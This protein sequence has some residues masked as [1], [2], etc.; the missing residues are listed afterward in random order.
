M[1]KQTALTAASLLTL[2]A[3]LAPNVLAEE[4]TLS[5]DIL[6]TNDLHATITDFGKV[7][8]FIDSVREEADHSLYLDA[9][10]IFSGSPVVDLPLGEPIITLLNEMGLEAMTI[11]NH[12]FD[13][14]QEA[15]AAR[16][17]EADFSWLSANTNVTDPTIPIEQPDPYEI[18]TFD[19]I[20]VGVLSLTQNPPATRPAGV[21][22][23]EFADYSDTIEEYDYLRDE[24]DILIALTHVGFGADQRIAEEFD[25]FDAIIGGH[26]HTTLTEPE[27]VNGTPIFQT[28]GY[29]ENVG[30]VTVEID[31]ASGDVTVDGYLQ[32][33]DEIT[34]VNASVA[35][36]VETYISDSEELLFQVVGTTETGL[37]RDP[38][39]DRDTSLG[40]FWTDAMRHA[41]DADFA[42][43]NN[44]GLRASIPAGEL[45]AN[46]I[47]TVEPFNN[48]VTEIL[49]TGEAFKEVLIYSFNR[50][51]SIDL[52]ASGF[53]YIVYVD[54][55]GK[56]VDIDL[57][58]DGEPLDLTAT[59]SVAL[60][61]FM[62]E[63]GSG[64]DFTDSTLIQEL[65]GPV[66]QAMF[67]YIE[68][69]DGEVNYDEAGENRIGIFPADERETPEVPAPVDFPFIDVPT[70]NFAYAYIQSLHA[71]GIINGMSETMFAPKGITTRGQFSAML[72]RLLDLEFDGADLP[73][74]L[75]GD[76]GAEIAALV[77]AGIVEG[78]PDGTFRQ[79]VV[80]SRQEM[81]VMAIRAL[82]YAVADELPVGSA[83]T[84]ADEDQISPYARES[85]QTAVE[86]G[87]IGGMTET[88]V[89]PLGYALRDQTAKVTYYVNEL[90]N[91]E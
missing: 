28:G 85:V 91:A 74:D 67:E 87:I 3:V 61:N 88:Q 53:A 23:L 56:L 69:L 55:D 18:F 42:V 29:A 81:T 89:Q 73:L 54:D 46:D 25:H 15:Y 45:T 76:I 10:D 90:I 51:D 17:A 86:L 78:Y 37:S 40:N 20:S 80:I 50:S 58:R 16:Q 47:Y 34:E 66:T 14:G 24:V 63:G 72:S 22:G 2:G 33:V 65:A 13:Y 39:Y 7:S 68:E 79:H 77:E 36:M 30:H 59:Y 75:R 6:H 52:Q 12:E 82:D 19:D 35:A 83:L 71:D 41:V 9:G 84:F 64:Y 11:G 5:I 48:E 8:G 38:R 27:I 44:G 1:F 70:S 62:Y 57:F 4:D 21:E 60:N 43:T 26:S 31:Q 49:M 32:P